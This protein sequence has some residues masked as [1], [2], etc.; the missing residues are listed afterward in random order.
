MKVYESLQI[1]KEEGP[2]EEYC[3]ICSNI[4]FAMKNQTTIEYIA[5]RRDWEKFSDQAY[6][7]WKNF[8]GIIDYPIEGSYGR[9]NS[10]NDHWNK[11]FKYGA[12]RWELLDHLIDWFKKKDI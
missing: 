2:Y 1:L 3:G 5:C 9:Y 6:Q 12:L 7:S 11:D 8:S 4:L 10:Y